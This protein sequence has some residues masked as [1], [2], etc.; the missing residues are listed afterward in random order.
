MTPDGTVVW[1]QV[2]YLKGGPPALIAGLDD[3]K[4]K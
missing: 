4:K 2:G 3:A 1:K